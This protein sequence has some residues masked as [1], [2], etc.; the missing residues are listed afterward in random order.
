[1]DIKLI[2]ADIELDY[3]EDFGGTDFQN[4][5]DSHSEV[6]DDPVGHW[7][8]IAK[9]RGETIN[10]DSVLVTLLVELHRKIDELTD[11][12]DGVK[13]PK[14]HLEHEGIIASIHFDYFRLKAPGF[15]KG[16][17]YY[18][19]AK[20]P[21]FPK[22]D[23]TLFFEAINETDGKIIQVHDRDEKAWSTYVAA[24]ERVM[25]RKLKEKGNNL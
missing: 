18:G 11:K 13:P 22:R 14:I 16:K 17:R 23:I 20:M 5:F 8:R 1:M 25:I 24:R 3:Q 4:D 21:S 9:A 12:I 2:P 6:D 7:L 15:Q 19:R 10:T